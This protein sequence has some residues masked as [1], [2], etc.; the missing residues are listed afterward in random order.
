M[1]ILSGGA[2][3]EAE[4]GMGKSRGVTS[5]EKHNSRKGGKARKC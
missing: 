4:E 3:H 2:A 5:D 1:L